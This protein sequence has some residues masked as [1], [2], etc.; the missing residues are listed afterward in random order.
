MTIIHCTNKLAAFLGVA[1]VP[2]PADADTWNAN[3]FT[4]ER[5]KCLCFTNASTGF[6][7]LALDVLKGDL[8][9]LPAYFKEL[10]HRQL[11]YTWPE[12]EAKIARYM[13]RV[14][15]VR[16]APSNNDKRTLGIMNEQLASVKARL[17]RDRPLL[18]QATA[19]REA[20]LRNTGLIRAKHLLPADK[21][22]VQPAKLMADLIGIH[23]SAG[24]LYDRRMMINSGFTFEDLMKVVK[25]E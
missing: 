24:E 6:S 12:D 23:T 5:R 9:D 8:K 11:I 19:L 15:E 3:L 2:L 7:L 14:G 10:L 21:K 13:E 20:Y 25:G 18:D 16:I 17:E 1:A 22:Y 4:H